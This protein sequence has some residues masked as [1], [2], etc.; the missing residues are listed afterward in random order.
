MNHC[1]YIALFRSKVLYSDEWELPLTPRP[2]CSTHLG[3][4]RQPFCARTLTTH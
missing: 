1:I 3:D 2:M 4:A